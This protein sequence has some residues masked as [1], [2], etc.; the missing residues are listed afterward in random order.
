MAPL[1]R[2]NP[3]ILDF[4][5]GTSTLPELSGGKA[6]N[7]LDGQLIHEHGQGEYSNS[8]YMNGITSTAKIT[9]F[10]TE[11]SQLTFKILLFYYHVEKIKRKNVIY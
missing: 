3:D 4:Q 9:S 10:P 5:E 8:I 2:K 1:L 6:Y 11:V 7:E